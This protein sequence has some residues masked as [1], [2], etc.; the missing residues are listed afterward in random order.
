MES[1]CEKLSAVSLSQVPNISG[2]LR[3]SNSEVALQYFILNSIPSLTLDNLFFKG[4]IH[5]YA[6]LQ[7]RLDIR[8]TF[9]LSAGP[10]SMC[11]QKGDEDV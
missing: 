1:A 10:L 6:G 4:P 2:Y 5:K 8:L 9:S 7:K 3:S 11:K